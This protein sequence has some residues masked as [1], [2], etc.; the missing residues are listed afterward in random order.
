[1]KDLNKFLKGVTGELEEKVQNLRNQATVGKENLRIIE[2]Q[3]NSLSQEVIDLNKKLKELKENLKN[4]REKIVGESEKRLA[5]A[6]LKETEVAQKSSG[7]TVKL[8]EADNLIKSNQ[9]LKKNLEL[10]ESENSKKEEKLNKLISM[11][12]EVIQSL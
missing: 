4:E 11:I 3:R 7:L 10:Q 12:N 2:E 9:G 5:N 1:M 8:K 6:I